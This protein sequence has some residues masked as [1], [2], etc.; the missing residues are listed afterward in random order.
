MKLHNFESVI[1][2]NYGLFFETIKLRRIARHY[3]RRSE[4]LGEA[5]GSYLYKK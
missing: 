1:L 2:H 5:S 4:V 3:Y